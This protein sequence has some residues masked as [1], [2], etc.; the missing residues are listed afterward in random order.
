MPGGLDRYLA[1]TNFQAQQTDMSVDAN[2]PDNLDA[3][4]PGL[5]AAHGIF[6]DKA[7]DRSLQSNLSMHRRLALGTASGVA[8]VALAARR[9]S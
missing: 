5:Q 8:L 7:K 1:R 9:R 2:R 6:D 4:V 3:P